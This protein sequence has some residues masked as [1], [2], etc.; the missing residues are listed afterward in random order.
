MKK[1]QIIDGRLKY[2]S[3]KNGKTFEIDLKFIPDYPG[4]Y[5]FPFLDEFKRWDK[6]SLRR[7]VA[8]VNSKINYHLKELAAEAGINKNISLHTAR[9]SFAHY[10][11]EKNMSLNVISKLLGHTKLTTTDTYISTLKKSD[12]LND[13]VNSKLW[14]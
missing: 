12:E 2:V 4:E 1:D 7:R 8:S 3:Q 6:K 11:D 10:A 14:D 5:L 13:A 9:H